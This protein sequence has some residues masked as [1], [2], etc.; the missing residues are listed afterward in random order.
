[1]YTDTIFFF[2]V[3]AGMYQLV[4]SRNQ[5]RKEKEWGE[6]W[7]KVDM[8]ISEKTSWLSMTGSIFEQIGERGTNNEPT[9]NEGTNNQ[10]KV[11]GKKR[12]KSEPK[13]T[14]RLS[15]VVN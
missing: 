11:G 1:M 4:I 6:E 9:T 2:L 8:K 15:T 7:K 13:E 10:K 14:Q 12:R 5:K 3:F